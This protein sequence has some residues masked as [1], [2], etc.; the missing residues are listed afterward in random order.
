MI[1]N[2]SPRRIETGTSVERVGDETLVYDQVRHMAFCLNRTSSAI[3][4]MCDGTH[5][6]THIAAAVTLELAEPITEDLVAF[7]LDQLHG[8]GLLQSAPLPSPPHLSRREM[9]EK[10]G[11]RALIL[12]P[13]VAAVLVPKAAQALSGVVTGSKPTS[14]QYRLRQSLLDQQTTSTPGK[15]GKSSDSS[16]P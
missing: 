13:V 14:A 2:E 5:T 10:L 11:A 15:S 1:S 3:W 9:V 4:R 12:L 6:S 16:A 7:A 8:D